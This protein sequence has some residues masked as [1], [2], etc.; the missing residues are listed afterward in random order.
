MSTYTM[1]LNTQLAHTGKENTHCVLIVRL[2][3]ATSKNKSRDGRASKGSKQIMWK[4]PRVPALLSS[5]KK[6]DTGRVFL[7]ELN[8]TAELL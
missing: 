4:G 1:L 7:F 3:I 5:C 8:S 6:C 2:S